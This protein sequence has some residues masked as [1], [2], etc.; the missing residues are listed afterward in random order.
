M[1]RPS[2]RIVWPALLLPLALALPFAAGCAKTASSEK[3]EEAPAKAEAAPA[4]AE[5]GLCKEHGVLEA[6]CT[7]CNPVLA[8]VF[9]AKGD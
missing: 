8:A 4:A 2:H 6:L 5:E 9:Q 1:R 7:K 3:I